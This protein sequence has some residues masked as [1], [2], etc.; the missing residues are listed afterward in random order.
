MGW[1]RVAAGVLPAAATVR[2][3]MVATKPPLLPLHELLTVLEAW[4]LAPSN[5]NLQALAGSLE[6][7]TAAYEARG[8]H[9]ASDA[10]PLRAVSLGVGTLAEPDALKRDGLRVSEIDF[11]EAGRAQVRIIID[12]DADAAAMLGDAIE[13][14]LASMSARHEAHLQR[15]QLEALDLAVRGIAGVLSVDRV[16]QLIVDRVRELVE[17]EYAALGIGD[18]F[19]RIEQFITS[20]MSDERRHQIGRLPTGLGLLGLIIREDRSFLIDDLAID[21]RRHGFPDHHPPMHAFLGTPVRSKGRSVGN[22]YLTNKLTAPAFSAADLRL[23]EMFALHA[24]IAIENARL[25]EEIGRLAIVE[26][27]Q[28]ISQ[29]LHDSVIQSLYATSL[30]LEDLPDLI[31]EDAS[32]GAARADRAIDA[33]H[34]TIRDIRN[35]IMGLQPEVLAEAGL[36][37]GLESLV[38]E[39]SANT[40][41]D[42]ELSVDPAIGELR[43]DEA[44]QLLAITREALSN[45]A[46][47]S[48]AT[49]VTIEL[50]RDE[51]AARLI[52][53]DNGRGFDAALPRSARQHGLANLKSRADTIGGRLDIVS[54]PGAG[55]RLTAIVPLERESS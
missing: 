18:E 21:S 35:F 50:G 10:E 53:T 9:L 23:V 3:A 29:D 16:L 51:D 52:V 46:R 32:E 31:A 22:F 36:T 43:G 8:L 40:L 47:H 26:E 4:R 27:R 6:R 12:G 30:S 2:L 37:V 33:I 49:R 24:G 54:E 48:G 14:A 15:T 5:R 17:A 28:R 11:S 13:L 41:I 42:V 34:S 19:G 7:L 38:A 25:H 1:P 45:I 55:T 44:S 39:F 20:G